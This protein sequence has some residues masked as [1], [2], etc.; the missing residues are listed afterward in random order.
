[1]AA[2]HTEPHIRERWNVLGARWHTITST[3]SLTTN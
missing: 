3:P 2:E 1:M